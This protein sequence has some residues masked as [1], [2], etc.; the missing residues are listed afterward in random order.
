MVYRLAQ[1]ALNNVAKHARADRVDMVLERGPENVSLII[2]DHGVGFNPSETAGAGLGL[3]GM[4][5]RASL[6]GAQLQIESTPG[7]GTTIILRIPAAALA[8]N[9]A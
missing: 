5:E 9:N 3:I 6:V 2:E 1:E 4:R 7:R 8:M